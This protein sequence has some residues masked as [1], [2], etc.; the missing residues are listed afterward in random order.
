MAATQGYEYF[1]HSHM[2]GHCAF[3]KMFML[4]AP[5]QSGEAPHAHDYY[6]AWYVLRGHCDHYVEGQHHPM[7][8][9]DAFILPPNFVHRT[10]LGEN[11][12][13]LCCEFS[14]DDTLFGP[15]S[16][17][18]RKMREI[19]NGMS[20]AMLFQ[21][22]MHDAQVKFTFCA[23]TQRR[24]EQLMMLMLEE[25]EN[26]ELLY[27]DFLQ[28]QVIEMLLLCIREYAQSPAHQPTE[29][30]YSRY[31]EIIQRA[32]AYIDVHY[33]DPL[34]LEDVC[35][36]STLSKTYFCYLFKQQTGKTFVEYLQALRVA[37]AAE[38]LTSCAD[39]ITEIGQ[40]AGFQD[41]THFAR[42]FK[43]LK[44]I[45]PREYRRGVKK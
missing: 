34:T 14:L 7:R 13:I 1:T 5:R 4:E 45:T 2:F 32:I 20:F 44:G 9:G 27:E 29:E 40:R 18:F 19:T 31:R 33:A 37:K 42:T 36:L 23:K 10:E 30:L 41:S 39:S 3:C 6:Q 35:R 28:V 21:Q 11:G 24:I 38:L 43:K 16:A 17:Y 26:A 22:D 12:K 15:S 8:A 25:Y